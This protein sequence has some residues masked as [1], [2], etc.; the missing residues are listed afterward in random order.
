[1]YDLIKNEALLTS[2]SQKKALKFIGKFFD[3]LRDSKDY[4]SNIIGKCRK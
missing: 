3:I 2:A 1:M 4:Q